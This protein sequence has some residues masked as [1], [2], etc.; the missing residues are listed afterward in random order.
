MIHFLPPFLLNKPIRVE[1]PSGVD[2]QIFHL[3][4][5]LKG[6]V[7]EQIDDQHALMRFKGHDLLV[8]TRLAL[9]EKMEGYFKVEDVHPQVILKPLWEEVGDESLVRSW[10]KRYLALDPSSENLVEK[11]S[12]LLMGKSGDNSLL[13]RETAGQ[14]LSLLKGFSM[15]QPHSL[16]ANRLKEIFLRS[17][18]FFERQLG[19]LIEA[20]KEGQIDQMVGKDL[21]GLLMMLRN[22]LNSSSLIEEPLREELPFLREIVKSL[23]QVVQRIEGYQVFNLNPFNP[24]GKMFL[25]LPVWFQSQFHFVEM[26]LSLPPHESDRFEKEALSILFF[27][28]MPEWERVVIEVKLREKVLFCRFTVSHPEAGQFLQEAFPDLALR[29][30]QIDLEP[31]LSV[32]VEDIEKIP[33]SL[34]HDMRGEMESLLNIMV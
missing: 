4:E 26:E 33:L 9:P 5:V 22:Q 7:I 19:H 13:V 25:L 17:G 6:T 31:H 27:L 21:K 1:L 11:L 10:V 23:E 29:L 16:D 2:Q 20:Q 32:A 28:Q 15:D 14:V 24:L 8:E 18:L 12:P 34:L 3:G 30:K